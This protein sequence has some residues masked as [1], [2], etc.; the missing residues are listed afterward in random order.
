MQAASL[1][2]SSRPVLF[3]IFIRFFLHKYFVFNLYWVMTL[4]MLKEP[5]QNN[6]LPMSF[7]FVR[8]QIKHT[9][10]SQINNL[11]S[12]ITTVFDVSSF[13]LTAYDLDEWWVSCGLDWYNRKTFSIQNL[14][15]KNVRRF[16]SL[17]NIRI[18]IS[19]YSTQWCHI[20]PSHV[21]K[22]CLQIIR[23]R[24]G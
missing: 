9:A 10:L 5:N 11:F 6:K 16:S 1:T 4:V 24:C 18:E 20:H 22:T 14:K 15:E 12:F 3:V 13:I 19:F 21:R 17:I 23:K 8:Y 7:C 2:P